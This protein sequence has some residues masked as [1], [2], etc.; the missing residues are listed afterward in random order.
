MTAAVLLI[1]AVTVAMV[2]GIMV[3]QAGESEGAKVGGVVDVEEMETEGMSYKEALVR[4]KAFQKNPFK[5]NLLKIMHFFIEGW[6]ISIKSNEFTKRKKRQRF[7]G[8]MQKANWS[9]VL[10]FEQN[11]IS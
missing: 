8:L 10:M 6:I 2:T 5:Y 3:E 7:R 4:E 11:V 1:H 9:L